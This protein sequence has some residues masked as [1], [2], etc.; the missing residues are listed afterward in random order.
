MIRTLYWLCFTFL[1]SINCWS[2][3]DT[4][5]SYLD[6]NGFN[7][8]K[9]AAIYFTK[10]YKQK[11]KWIQEKYSNATNVLTTIGTYADKSCAI[12]QGPTTSYAAD[13]TKMSVTLFEN[14]SPVSKTF[15][16]KNGVKKAF[17]S[18]EYN[19]NRSWDEQGNLLANLVLEK[20]AKP[21][22]AA[23]IR[24]LLDSANADIAVASKLP[25][26]VYR[27]NA[28]FVVDTLGNITSVKAFSDKC[29]K[30]ADEVARVIK[31]SPKWEPAILNNKPT[32]FEGYKELYFSVS[33]DDVGGVGVADLILKRL[34]R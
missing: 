29:P 8:S 20:D 7:C 27:V 11:G 30:C 6:S 26:G 17:M 5:Y 22:G 21:V 32:T 9:D 15:Y 4:I 24:H 23:W 33:D 16:Y 3:K 12:L 19:I 10:Q 31:S 34:K 28:K 13:G 1:Y 14:G 25:V 18:F 2:Q